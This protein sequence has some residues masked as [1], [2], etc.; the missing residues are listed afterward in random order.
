M[1]C[2]YDR[3]PE[4]VPVRSSRVTVASAPR[5]AVMRMDSQV[6]PPS[7]H[8]SSCVAFRVTSPVPVNEALTTTDSSVDV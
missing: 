4:P 5:F 6:R 2:M 8:R 7:P 1:P 3:A